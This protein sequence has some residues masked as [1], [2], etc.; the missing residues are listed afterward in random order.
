MQLL[1]AVCRRVFHKPG[2]VHPGPAL[3]T[4][5]A[6]PKRALAAAERDRAQVRRQLVVTITIIVI[7][8]TTTTNS[9]ST[10]IGAGSGGSVALV[11]VVAWGRHAD[12]LQDGSRSVKLIA[13][14]RNVLGAHDAVGR[15][16]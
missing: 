4:L 14:A 15:R 13:I 3:Q 9:S 1:A 11:A 16:G 6:H 5:D 10:T 8:S 7:T 2:H 12:G